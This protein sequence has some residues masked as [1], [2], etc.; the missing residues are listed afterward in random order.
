ML[1]S[2]CMHR[3][4]QSHVYVTIRA[5]YFLISHILGCTPCIVVFLFMQTCL[6]VTGD[7]TVN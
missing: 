7:Q 4:E 1:L 5:C 3:K 6:W 2:M